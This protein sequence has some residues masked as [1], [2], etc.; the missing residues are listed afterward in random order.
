MEYEESCR[1]LGL[2]HNQLKSLDYKK[3]R[4]AY[5]K[6]SLRY[7]PDKNNG[8]DEEFKKIV[9]AYENLFEFLASHKRVNRSFDQENIKYNYNNILEEILNEIISLKAEG[10]VK[11]KFNWDKKFIVTTIKSLLKTFLN[12][13]YSIFDHLDSDTCIQIYDFLVEF[14]DIGFIDQSYL[15]NLKKILQK[16]INNVIILEPSLN[17]LLSDKIYKLEMFDKTFYVPLWHNELVY[18]YSDENNV[19]VN[20]VVKIEPILD[21]NFFIDDK[22]DLC[23]RKEIKFSDLERIFKNGFFDVEFA[24]KKYK[25]PSEKIKIMKES[26]IFKFNDGIIRIN[27]SDMFC[28]KERGSI[29]IEVN[30]IE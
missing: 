6:K 1:V 8:K 7:H 2:D 26:Q 17:D 16:K 14:N 18:S 25:I 30:I 11:S 28:S 12:K 15:N 4:S 22:N 27:Q 9:A 10:A 13:S 20:F 5:L 29:M 24:N 19:T 21:D 23:V 3:L